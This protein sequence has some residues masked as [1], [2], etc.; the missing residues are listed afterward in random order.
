MTEA[1]TRHSSYHAPDGPDLVRLTSSPEPAG[2]LVSLVHN[3]LRAMFLS[4]AYT[5]LGA[6]TAIRRGN[7]RLG[8][9]PPLASPEAVEGTAADLTRFTREHPE[10]EHP[11]AVFV[12]VF[13]GPVRT[14]DADF[15]ADLWRHLAALD[16]TN[17]GR[18]DAHPNPG[19]AADPGFVYSGRNFFVV[20]LHPGASRW[21]RR[22]AWP[23]LVFNA[24]SHGDPLR[25]ADQFDRMTERIRNRDRRLQGEVNPSL[26]FSRV[27]QFSGR[28]VDADWT[29]PV[30][31]PPR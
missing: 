11:V 23:T 21:A 4:T 9:Y 5:C 25:E 31:R 10:P 24:L 20:G 14:G 12:S 6:A 1:G 22:F 30:H 27:S 16:E 29:C 2:P 17:P 7:Y 26:E 8:V 15:E 18:T 13:D 28:A 19:T 3:Q